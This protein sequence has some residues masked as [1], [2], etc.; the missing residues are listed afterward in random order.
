MSLNSCEY[1]NDFIHPEDVKSLPDDVPED[2]PWPSNYDH[3]SYHRWC[4]DD[5]V[6]PEIRQ[7]MIT[8]YGD[9]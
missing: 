8:K 2:I 6:V 7:E 3:M 4:F 1:C 5:Y 9:G